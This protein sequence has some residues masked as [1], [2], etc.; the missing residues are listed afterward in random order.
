MRILTIALLSGSAILAAN[1][2]SPETGSS[3]KSLPPEETVA[4]IG[5]T[6]DPIVT[7]QTLSNEDIS[8]WE[9]QRKRYLECP[10]CEAKQAFPGD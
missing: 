2:L 6:I 10:E 8:E 9:A 1:P 3:T 5:E 4:V 7:G